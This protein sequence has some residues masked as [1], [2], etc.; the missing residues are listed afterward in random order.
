MEGLSRRLGNELQRMRKERKITQRQIAERLHKTTACI[1][2]YE[3]GDTSMDV[4]SLCEYCAVLHVSPTE[5]LMPFITTE[6]AVQSAP[7]LPFYSVPEL[8]LY[9]HGGVDG[10]VFSAKMTF[11]PHAASAVRLGMVFDFCAKN[12]LLSASKFVFNGEIEFFPSITRV[13][14]RKVNNPFDLIL[15]TAYNAGEGNNYRIGHLTTLTSYYSPMSSKCIISQEMIPTK[16]DAIRLLQPSKSE[17][18][19]LKKS[20]V[21]LPLNIYQKNT[22]TTEE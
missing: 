10:S 1:S 7:S 17:V 12:S 5:L 11:L 2:K 22:D 14:L 6:Q 8:Y 16:E 3:S 21:F 4:E 19:Q 13:L 15:V 20:G 18:S 9:W